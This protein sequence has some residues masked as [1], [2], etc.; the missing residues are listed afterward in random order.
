MTLSKSFAACQSG[1]KAKKLGLNN[2]RSSGSDARRA[3]PEA[4][5]TALRADGAMKV[6]IEPQRPE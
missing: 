2:G 6:V 4:M 1:S 5:E 3:R